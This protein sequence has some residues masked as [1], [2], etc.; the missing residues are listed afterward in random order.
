V[1]KLSCQ[2]VL[3][4]L[5][6]YLDED[7]QAELV[8][9][10]DLHIGHCHNCRVEVDTVRQTIFIFREDKRVFLPQHLSD[11][12]QAALEEVYRKGGCGEN[13]GSEGSAEA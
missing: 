11:R 8:S 7:A 5:S 10:V 2:E 12:L 4:H 13:S 9:Q 6:E 3:D 1:R